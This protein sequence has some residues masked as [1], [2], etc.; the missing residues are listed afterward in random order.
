M[1][2]LN[3][4]LDFILSHLE[5]PIWPR[6]IS[7]GMAT[8]KEVSDEASALNF[9]EYYRVDCK[10]NAYRPVKKQ[11][12]SLLSLHLNKKYL[13]S[14]L[15]RIK[16]LLQGYPTILELSPDTVHI[17]Q[18]IEVP[19]LETVPILDWTCE[20]EPSNAFLK[21]AEDW[22]SKNHADRNHNPSF[23]DCMLSIPG[24]L[25][26]ASVKDI[27]VVQ[28]WNGIRPKID[29]RVFEDF[30]YYLIGLKVDMSRKGIGPPASSCDFCDAE[31]SYILDKA[32]YTRHRL[33]NKCIVSQDIGAYQVNLAAKKIPS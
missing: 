19:L 8:S 33:C 26:S 7:A 24:S 23:R 13:E 20:M 10:I 5:P 32:G 21:F 15:R 17:Y 11:P 12:P 14:V 25:S 28:E 18:P 2:D 1:M 6:E 4:G 27:N 9:F 16:K 22:L 29:D 3:E 31:I 30:R